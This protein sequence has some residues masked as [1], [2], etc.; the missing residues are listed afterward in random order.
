MRNS[1]YFKKVLLEIDSEVNAKSK[2][3]DNV[4]LEGGK[5]GLVLY[6]LFCHQFYKDESYRDQ[7]EQ[8][9]DESIEILSEISTLKKFKPDFKTDSLSNHIAGFGKTLLFAQYKFD[10]DYDFTGLYE[11]ISEILSDLTERSLKAG[12]FDINSGA[13]S[14]GYFFLN[15]YYHEK[16]ESS[17]NALLGIISALEKCAVYY[18]ENEVYWSSPSLEN[19]VYLGLSHG[20]AMIINFITKL[21]ELK[22]IDE[23]NHNALNLLEK[24]VTFVINQKRDLE[25]GYFPSK[26][27]DEGIKEAQF[28]ICYGD[29][30][31]LYSLY[32]ASAIL[33][34]DQLRQE[35][36]EL[37][38]A[39]TRRKEDI[40]YTFDGGITYGA[41][42]VACVF[43]KLY[44]ITNDAHFKLAY[45]YW[46]DQIL[47]Y[48]TLEVKDFAGFRNRFE[49]L[50][51]DKV[52]NLTFGWG[53]MGIGICLMSALKPELPGISELLIIGI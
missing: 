12:D 27:P 40:R 50:Q 26:Y 43:K 17:K 42:G 3:L 18:K 46:Y 24:A 5:S 23:D 35:T 34:N 4:T 1:G 41:S 53:I 49:R 45:E 30:G 47:K 51:D 2:Y 14:A 48:R 8:Q 6:N 36:F 16:D 20:S 11:S 32:N 22:V 28:T 38:I 39:C 7:A 37:L 10:Y 31:V 52:F 19:Q 9:I 13:F 25:S 33:K 29:L 15:R 21:F 44:E